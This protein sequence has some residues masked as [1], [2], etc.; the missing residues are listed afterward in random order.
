MDKVV[1]GK[2]VP[3]F[4]D[5]PM[6]LYRLS[7]VLNAVIISTIYFI[8]SHISPRLPICPRQVF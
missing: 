5:P 2:A 4:R 7:D 8:I 6:S 1:S 3:C